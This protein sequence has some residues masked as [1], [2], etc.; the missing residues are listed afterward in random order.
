MKGFEGRKHSEKTLKLLS[1]NRK[2][3]KNPMFGRH[4][5]EEALKKMR[6]R[7]VLNHTPKFHTQETKDKLRVARLKQKIL[8]IDTSIE[9][10]VKAYLEDKG[11]E[12]IHPFNFGNMYQCDFY[13]PTIN[14]IVEC[15]GTYWHSRPD[16]IKRDIA[17]DKYAKELG[18]KMLRLTEQQINLNWFK[19]DLDQQMNAS[20]SNTQ[21]QF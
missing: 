11:I 10:K 21:P 18:F 13:I 14:L 7:K 9:L 12:F 16:A 5:S 2:G 1:E 20:R 8:Q 4:H 17:K 6:A 19:S 3:S 15:D